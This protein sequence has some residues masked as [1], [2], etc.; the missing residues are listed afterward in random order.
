[1]I[2]Y[3]YVK[4]TPEK[5]PLHSLDITYDYSDIEY[6]DNVAI[7]I[8]EP[9]VILDIDNENYFNA[10]CEIVN[11]RNIK[12]RIMKTDRGGHFWFKSAEIL[13]NNVN[14]NTPI[15][16]KTDIKCWGKKS[17]VTVKK[18]GVWRE[19]IR[20][21]E[22]VDELPFWL[23]PIKLNKELFDLKDGDGR[24]PALFSYIIPLLN[25]KFTK[26]QIREIFDIIN[27]FIFS[28]PLHESEIDK[29]FEGN[30]IF[31][32][33]DLCFFSGK[34]FLHN[35]FV[36][37]M[38]ESEFFK[39]Y[40]SKMYIYKKGLY[41]PN[42]DEIYRRMLNQIPSLK[43]T[44]MSEAFENLRLKV[45]VNDNE[46][47]PMIINLRNGLYDLR[48]NKF[49][50]HSPYVFTINQLNCNYD[51]TAK[52]P[53]VDKFLNS[54]S[55]NN[56][57]IRE[58]LEQIL[59][60][61]LIGDCRFQYAFVL[62]GNGANGKSRFLE[63]IMNWIGLDNCSSL[64]LEDLSERFRT[65][66]LVGKIANIGDD[67]GNDLLKNSAIFKK[68][69]TGDSITVEFKHGQP[70]QFANRAKMLFAANAL[71]PCTDKSD[72]FFRRIIIVPFRAVFKPGLP[73]YD[74]NINDKLG[75]ETAK[76]YILNL[77][78]R[79]AQKMIADKRIT[80]PES[81]KT[82]TQGYEMDNNNVLQWLSSKPTIL[83]KKL[84]E[85]YTE[86]C[87][88][89]NT[90]NTIAVKITKF[91]QEICRKFPEYNIDSK[92]VDGKIETRWQKREI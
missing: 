2:K 26:E 62:L 25:L 35:I 87:L 45:T 20:Q 89:C 80:V 70:F 81:I 88:Y 79:S 91:V 57:E 55:D 72:G 74:P 65:S 69:V 73:G 54:I 53:D 33:K 82:L 28:D 14:I 43:R 42:E 21:D 29:M 15:T 11:A 58:M 8:D 76:S 31:D 10:L 22:N 18:N 63:M 51:E 40:G 12:T 61:L 66:Q 52:C 13:S 84:Q 67:S 5:V 32:K 24:D 50:E 44:Q 59:G 90:Y 77:A 3:N 47:D 75:T 86:Y 34:T 27:N 46:I 23:K 6:E 38:I 83:D 36:D 16:I 1:M 7:K 17:L 60:Y 30:D 92:E 37:W 41:E 4:I 56:P 64:A 68:L 78:I 85:T 39:S 71:P 19:W 9:Y 48:E 49:I